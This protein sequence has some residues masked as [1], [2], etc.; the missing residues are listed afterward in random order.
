[1]RFHNPQPFLIDGT[2]KIPPRRGIAEKRVGSPLVR[3][4]VVGATGYPVHRVGNDR[5]DAAAWNPRE[6]IAAVT[7]EYFI[8]VRYQPWVDYCRLLWP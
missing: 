5:I 1:M 2:V 3:I 8:K 7:R 4:S 6:Q